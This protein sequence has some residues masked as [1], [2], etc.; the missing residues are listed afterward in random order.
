M[1][2]PDDFTEYI[3]HVGSFTNLHSIIRSGL[4]AGGKDA[5]QV[6]QAAFFTAVNPMKSKDHWQTEFNLT[7]AKNCYLHAKLEGTPRH[8]VLGQLEIRRVHMQK[9]DQNRLGQKNELILQIQKRE[10]QSLI[11]VSTGTPVGR[12]NQSFHNG[13]DCER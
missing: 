5:K 3:Y 13:S 6:R 1:V 9:S 10:N 8:G 4:V 2:L 12:K 7:M 11:Q